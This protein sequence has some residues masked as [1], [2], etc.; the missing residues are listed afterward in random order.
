[1]QDS[2]LYALSTLTGEIITKIQRFGLNVKGNVE[3]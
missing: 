1:M 2:N 3:L